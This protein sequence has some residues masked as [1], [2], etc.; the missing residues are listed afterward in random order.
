MITSS[1]SVASGGSGG[2]FRPSMVIGGCAGAAFGQIAHQLAPQ[3]VPHPETYAIVGAAGFFAGAARAPISTIIMVR[4]LT[5]DFGLLVPTMLVCSFTFLVSSNWQL[6]KSQVP[7]RMD[8]PAH[9]GDFLVDVLEGLK[10]QSVYTPDNGL[11]KIHERETLD[12]IVHHL[13][14]GQQHYFPVV[15]NEGLMIGIFSD[16]DVRA[17]LYDD[18]L[19]Q[20]VNATDVM[21]S[22][23]DCVI[24]GDD[25][26]VAMQKFTSLLIDELPVVD[27]DQP[28]KLLGFLSRK[29]LIAAYNRRVLEHRQSVD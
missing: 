16:V 26:N 27:K 5:G 14:E 4:E 6:Y 24:P 1:L 8:S 7:T 20:L 23:V 13:A 28:G 21:T 19:W 12:Q 3:F 2:V 15:D 25:L 18:T 22:P 9:R 10:V 11:L 29:E 17:Y